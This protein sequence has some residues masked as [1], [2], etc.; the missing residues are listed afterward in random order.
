MLDLSTLKRW[1]VEYSPSVFYLALSGGRDSVALL[2]A[3]FEARLNVPIKAIY[4]NHG[5]SEKSAFWG[6]FCQNLT[7][8]YGIVCE[9]VQ[10]N[11][12]PNGNAEALAR[13]ARYQAFEALLPE[14]GV[15]LTAHHHD[16][17]VETFFLQ[18]LRGA[19]LDGLSA[20]P[21]R[22]R[23]GRGEH[24][25][26]LLKV[27]RTEIDLYLKNKGL[28]YIDD[29]SND[30]ERYQRNFL[31][32]QIIPELTKHYPHFV[33]AVGRSVTHLQ[34]ALQLQKILLKQ[35]FQEKFP[36]H[37]IKTE[38]GEMVQKALFRAWL[39][40]NGLILPEKRFLN[41][42]ANCE[43]PHAQTELKLNGK[44]LLQYRGK[45]YLYDDVFPENPLNFTEKI[46]WDG[47]GNLTVL[48]PKA[49]LKNPQWTIYPASAS[50]QL[51]QQK[52]ATNLRNFYQ[53]QGINP[54]LRQKLPVLLDG[55]QCVW[56]GHFGVCLGYEDLEIIWKKHE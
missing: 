15:L 8:K 46:N 27:S 49:L 55:N 40:E 53:N 30:D 21:E 13:T 16:D 47:M 9:M 39:K 56:L 22:K 44:I 54:I 19:G 33:K 1:T 37:Q 48:D 34:E 7:T 6:E 4:I 51:P 26:P 3:L 43:N 20:M 2:D 45:I 52:Y 18:L 23:F 29:P 38:R 35:E 5:W 12:S 41:F 28:N 24:W 10:L 14:K 32:H 31:R 50:V 36:L 42:L 11:L 17:Q 25:R